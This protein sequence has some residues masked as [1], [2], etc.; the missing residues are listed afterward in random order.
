MAVEE[1][2]ARSLGLTGKKGNELW[3]LLPNLQERS[4]CSDEVGQKTDPPLSFLAQSS[5]ICVVRT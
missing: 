4:L 3:G 2:K 5:H 1:A